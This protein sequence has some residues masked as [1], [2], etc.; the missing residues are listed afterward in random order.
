MAMKLS[1]YIAAHTSSSHI[2]EYQVECRTTYYEVRG[3][4]ASMREGFLPLIMA[5]VCAEW[6]YSYFNLPYDYNGIRAISAFGDDRDI[7]MSKR[8]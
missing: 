6:C 4:N 8:L 7:L 2:I 1:D 3:C 5:L